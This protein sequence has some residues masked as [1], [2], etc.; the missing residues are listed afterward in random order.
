[1][2]FSLSTPWHIHRIDIDC[3]VSAN[4]SRYVLLID[5]CLHVHTLCVQVSDAAKSHTYCQPT[6]PTQAR[7]E[8]LRSLLTIDEKI[9]MIA[10]QPQL[11]DT[12]GVHTAGKKSIGLPP[13][14]W[15]AVRRSSSYRDSTCLSLRMTVYHQSHIAITTTFFFFTL[16]LVCDP[17]IHAIYSWT[18][19]CMCTAG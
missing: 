14:Y 1:M 5:M 8:A 18:W 7:L 13:Y 9:A 6:L 4:Y 10:P 12:C 17:Q 16:P 15:Y 2:V 11:G 19:A 3:C